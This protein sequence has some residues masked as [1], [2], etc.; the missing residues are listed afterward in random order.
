MVKYFVRVE[1]GTES[2]WVSRHGKTLPRIGE[3]YPL[4]YNKTNPTNRE[5]VIGYELIEGK[6]VDV[7]HR[8][9]AVRKPEKGRLIIMM[10]TPLVVIRRK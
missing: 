10:D 3:S 4:G 2:I 6:V 8:N 7:I 1:D 5:E 9:T